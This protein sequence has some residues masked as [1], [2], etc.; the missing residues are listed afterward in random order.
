[1]SDTIYL[2][3]ALDADG[4]PVGGAVAYFYAAGTTT[5]LTVY[6]DDDL[7]T[8]RG[9]AVQADADGAFPQCWVEGGTEVKVDVEDSD[10]VSLP[11]YPRD[12][13][14]RFSQ[15]GQSAEDIVHTPQ[16]GNTADNVQSALNNN[17][18]SINRLNEFGLPATAT[19]SGG[20][21][22]ITGTV[23][24][25]AY[26]AGQVFTFIANHNAVGS[27]TDT[28]N[29]DGVGAVQLKKRAGSTS[30][31]NLSPND[32][33]TGDTVIVAYDGTHFV[34]LNVM[35]GD[36]HRFTTEGQMLYRGAANSSRLNIGTAGQMLA[37][38]SGATAPEWVDPDDALDLGVGKVIALAYVSDGS[39]GSFTVQFQSG[40]TV[41]RTAVGEYLCTFDATQPDT[42]YVVSAISGT[43]NR[44][45]SERVA[46]RGT[47]TFRI[48]CNVGG[49][50]TLS[51]D[52]FQVTVTRLRT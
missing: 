12:Q 38:N 23:T 2:P 47:G 44:M 42:N 51:D 11:G 31:N 48:D 36:E 52:P 25:T 22:A 21:Y 20:A 19:G 30:K 32:F 29:V 15:G 43:V 10:G 41:T 33:R 26:A 5:P 34:V 14:G 4:D 17:T 8:A 46:S 27:G 16:T 28:L 6:E 45:V 37:V 49:A 13:N 35:T 39:S 18:K 9:T 50:A 7:T 24:V 1:M 3:R 40:I